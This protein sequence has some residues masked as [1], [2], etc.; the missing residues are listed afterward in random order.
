MTDDNG[1][2]LKVIIKAMAVESIVKSVIEVFPNKEAELHARAFKG[3]V[4]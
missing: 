4:F 2:I 1:E 3:Y